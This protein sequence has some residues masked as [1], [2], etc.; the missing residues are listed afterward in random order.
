MA[1][2]AE[3]NSAAQRAGGEL[4]LPVPVFQFS[5]LPSRIVQAFPELRDWLVQQNIAF[6]KHTDKLNTLQANVGTAIT[7]LQP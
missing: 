1:T 7:K 3:L 6:A 2:Q 4:T 5:A